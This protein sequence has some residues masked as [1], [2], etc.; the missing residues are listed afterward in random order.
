L[1]FVFGV[2]SVSFTSI[3]STNFQFASTDGLRKTWGRWEEAD[4]RGAVEWRQLP[5]PAP[6]GNN[7]LK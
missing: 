5:I 6:Y 2:W 4:L 1:K 3:R 7:K